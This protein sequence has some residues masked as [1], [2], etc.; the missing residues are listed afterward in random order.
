MDTIKIKE[1]IKNLY[2]DFYNKII[3]SDD[4]K[5]CDYLLLDFEYKTLERVIHNTEFPI[6]DNLKSVFVTLQNHHSLIP[7]KTF[8]R[9]SLI[10]D[11]CETLRTQKVNCT[12]KDIR[13][14]FP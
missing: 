4:V 5:K 10:L 1:I 14:E 9:D 8:I 2:T 7:N 11:K 3:L 6:G 12:P 13:K